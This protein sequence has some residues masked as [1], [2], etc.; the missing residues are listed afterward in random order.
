M[1]FYVF[2]YLF[3]YNIQSRFNKS[4]PIFS[5]CSLNFSVLFDG[6]LNVV[7]NASFWFDGFFSERSLWMSIMVF[8]WMLVELLKMLRRSGFLELIT[9]LEIWSW[10]RANC[11]EREELIESQSALW[12]RLNLDWRRNRFANFGREAEKN[13]WMI[14]W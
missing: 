2:F 8:V 10:R 4:V 12:Q 7:W 9:R 11:L 1:G 3:R 13:C 14:W 5:E 6:E